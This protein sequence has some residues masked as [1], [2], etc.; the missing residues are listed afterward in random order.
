MLK[1]GLEERKKIQF[2]I[3]CDIHSFCI[4]NN[5]TYFLSSGTLIGAAR[6]KGYIPWDD[7]IDIAM[8]RPDYDRFFK[9]YK[10]ENYK[11]VDIDTDS[12]WPYI[13]GKV[14][15]TRTT[16]KDDITGRG[17]EDIMVTHNDLGVHIDVFPLDGLPS[18]KL[19][20]RLHLAKIYFLTFLVNRKTVSAKYSKGFMKKVF[21]Y[22]MSMVLLP[23]KASQILSAKNSLVRK[24]DW[25]L[26]DLVSSLATTTE[27]KIFRK[28]LFSSVIEI[29]FEKKMFYAPVGYDEWL[30]IV[31]GDYMQ[32]PPEE[33]RV[34]HS[35][36]AYWKNA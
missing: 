32:L 31:F 18:C 27:R 11:A 2:D 7:D 35:R 8:P 14:N 12:T 25:N 13:M 23:F 3:L 5:I 29:P 1:I 26:S 9:L 10:S 33:K 17:D 36:C 34:C 19:K 16:L 15:D 21:H 4:E 28:S 6:H 22:C 24:Y 30:R 20:C